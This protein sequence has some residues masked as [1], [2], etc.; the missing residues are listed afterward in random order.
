MGAVTAMP[1]APAPGAM[2]PVRRA[3]RQQQAAEDGA[4]AA[5][6]LAACAALAIAMW[7]LLPSCDSH[8]AA[9]RGWLG[10]KPSAAAAGAAAVPP[11]LPFNASAK[12][13]HMIHQVLP[14]SQREVP[15]RLAPITA[16]WQDHH[17]GW[18]YQL[19][20]SSDIDVLVSKGWD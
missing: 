11:A 5:R 12:V 14:K 18:G 16:T 6:L 9:R 7:L 20:H 10:R 1:P 8:G 17:Q 15:P 13:P 4:F 2:T 19:W 3:A